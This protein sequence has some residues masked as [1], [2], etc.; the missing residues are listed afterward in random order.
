[1]G[2]LETEDPHCRQVVINTGAAVLNVN[3]RHTPEWTFPAP[4]NDA[5]A[6]FQWAQDSAEQHGIDRRRIYVG[7]V[8]AGGTLAITVALR[9]LREVTA[10][11][12][13]ACVHQQS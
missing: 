9:A 8:S 10:S 3:Y 11:R 6:A 12:L 2:S 4:V 7:G 13:P 1:M 5:W